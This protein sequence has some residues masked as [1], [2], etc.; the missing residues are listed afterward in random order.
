MANFIALTG[1][2][3]AVAAALFFPAFFG[4]RG[5]LT[6]NSWV[7][8]RIGST[9][10]SEDA[11]RAGHQAALRWGMVAVIDS[12]ICNAVGLIILLSGGGVEKATWGPGVALA[13]NFVAAIPYSVSADRAAKRVEQSSGS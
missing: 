1:C 6:R 3:L 11:W 10:A 7:G 2:S 9:G 8:I 13:L 12:V 5:V 4:S